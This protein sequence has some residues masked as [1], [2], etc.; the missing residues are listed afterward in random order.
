ML[1]LHSASSLLEKSFKLQGLLVIERYY[2]CSGCCARGRVVEVRVSLSSEDL[3]IWIL[4]RGDD[5]SEGR[6]NQ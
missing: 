3:R 2:S 6:R 4:V 5:I 1:S